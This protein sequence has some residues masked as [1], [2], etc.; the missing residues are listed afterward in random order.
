MSR[1]ASVRQIANEP[2]YY[3]N[4]YIGYAKTVLTT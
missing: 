3:V 4:R 2:D 1:R